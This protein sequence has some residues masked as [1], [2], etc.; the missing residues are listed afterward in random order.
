MAAEPPPQGPIGEQIA[1][2]VRNG[3]APADVAALV[4]KA[5]QAN[6][7]YIFTHPDMRPPLEMRVDRFLAAYRKLGAG[8]QE[9]K[10]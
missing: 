3:M 2:L 1:E 9:I 7:L 4:R 10:R 6:E 8:P 5:V